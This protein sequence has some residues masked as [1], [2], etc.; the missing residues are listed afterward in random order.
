MKLAGV[1]TR[2]L[3]RV[4]APQA[5]RCAGWRDQPCRRL[6]YPPETLCPVCKPKVAQD[7]STSDFCACGAPK[8]KVA[9]RCWACHVAGMRRLKP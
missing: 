4:A 7:H 8:C 2:H 9:R 3:D 1:P 6:V 5:V